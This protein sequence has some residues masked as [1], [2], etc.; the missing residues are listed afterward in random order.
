LIGAKGYFGKE[1][2]VVRENLVELWKN[3]KLPEFN[4]VKRVYDFVHYE[5]DNGKKINPIKMLE[6][7]L[8]IERLIKILE[9]RRESRW[10]TLKKDT[11]KA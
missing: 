2:D 10:K 1:I 6:I 4:K 11:Q 5:T 7:I 3:E 8:I 9:R